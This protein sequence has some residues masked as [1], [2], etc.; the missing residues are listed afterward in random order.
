MPRPKSSPNTVRRL[1]QARNARYRQRI[2]ELER[3]E[4]E[5]GK[6]TEQT[7][8]DNET[9]LVVSLEVPPFGFEEEED[10]IEDSVFTKEITDELKQIGTSLDLHLCLIS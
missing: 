3:A 5:K 7:A 1:R 4:L 8:E 10:A 6:E 2:L 9:D